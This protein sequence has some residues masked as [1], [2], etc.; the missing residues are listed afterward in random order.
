MQIKWN[1][2][3]KATGLW[4]FEKMIRCICKYVDDASIEN[5]KITVLGG[6]K[7]DPIFI[8]A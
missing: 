8:L 5:K 3:Y 1:I 6:G 2:K 7:L 4:H